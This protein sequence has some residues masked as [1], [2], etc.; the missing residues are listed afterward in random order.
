[1]MGTEM[2]AWSAHANL[3]HMCMHV[4]SVQVVGGWGN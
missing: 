2:C 3:L 1:M 4:G